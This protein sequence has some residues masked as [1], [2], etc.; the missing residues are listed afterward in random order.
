[1]ST[2]KKLTYWFVEIHKIKFKYVCFE[3][4]NS[5][6]LIDIDHGTINA[7]RVR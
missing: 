5:D 7:A 4:I 2:I 6:V 1:M 3:I